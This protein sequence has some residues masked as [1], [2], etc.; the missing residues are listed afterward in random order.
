MA[1][2]SSDLQ[3]I[4]LF[5]G[6]R[7]VTGLIAVFFSEIMFQSF[8]HLPYIEVLSLWLKGLTSSAFWR[9]LPLESETL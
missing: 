9:S 2:N 4:G 7:A 6:E 5:Q 3:K 8:V 1:K